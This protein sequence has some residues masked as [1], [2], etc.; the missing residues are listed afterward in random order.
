MGTHLRVLSK[1][2]T[3]NT[4]LTGIKWFSKNR[5]VLML[6]VKVASAWEGIFENHLNPVVLVF[7]GKLS[8][9][10]GVTMCQGFGH[11]FK[12]FLHHFVLAKL[13]TSGTRVNAICLEIS[14]TF[15]SVIW[16]I[17]IFQNSF[18]INHKFTKYLKESLLL[19]FDQNLSFKYFLKIAFVREI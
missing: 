5:Y 7:I 16:T 15:N 6:R 14:L 9:L 19:D 10:G 12:G 18:G 13:A 4:N 1:S 8:T 2:Y 11:F 3:M 17:S